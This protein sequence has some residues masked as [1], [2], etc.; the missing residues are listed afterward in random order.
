M[1]IP[2]SVERDDGAQ[3]RYFVTFDG[4]EALIEAG[5]APGALDIVWFGIE[6]WRQGEGLSEHALQAM[7][8][9]FKKPLNPWGVVPEAEA[10]WAKMAAR[11]YCAPG[12]PTSH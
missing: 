7:Q 4:G 5:E 9:H 11:G 12:K 2:I 10:F 8:A 3:D 6:P 1:A